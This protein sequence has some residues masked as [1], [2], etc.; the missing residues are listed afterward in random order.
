MQFISLP[1]E[2]TGL[3][4]TFIEIQKPM[5]ADKI[6]L[7]L[8]NIEQTSETY[9]DGISIIKVNKLL[10]VLLTSI[11]TLLLARVSIPVYD[12]L[13]INF[14]IKISIFSSIGALVV[15]LFFIV[16]VQ[17]I[18][19]L[20]EVINHNKVYLTITTAVILFIFF[21]SAI[22]II[23]SALLFYSLLLLAFAILSLVISAINVNIALLNKI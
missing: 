10:F 21:S 1:L 19:R 4:L 9:I 2:V 5:L 16:P 8:D 17:V 22:S 18:N 23:I 6:E 7:F 14:L 15:F 12:W 3:L 20:M 13:S 11:S